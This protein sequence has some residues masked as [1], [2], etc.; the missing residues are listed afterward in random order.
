MFTKEETKVL[1]SLATH[2]KENAADPINAEKIAFW[3]RHTALKG[4]RP[5]VFVHPDGAWNELLP[6]ASLTCTGDFARS[7]EYKLRQRLFR[8]RYIPDDI[9]QVDVLKIQKLIHNSMWGLEP[10]FTP[11]NHSGGAWHHVVQIEKPSDWKKLKMPLV[12][13]DETETQ[14][15]FQAAGDVLGD[16]LKLESVGQTNCSFHMLHWYCDYRGLENLFMDLVEEPEMVHE[17]MEFFAE[18]CISMFPQLEAQ[19][20]LSLNNDET[21]H[22]TGG[23]GYNEEL[24]GEDFNPRHVKLKNLWASAEAQEFSSVSPAM[25]EEF[26]LQYE[27]RVFELFGLNGYGCCDDL[28]DKLDGVL[29]I[30]NLRRVAVCPWA[31]IAKFTP[32]LGKKYIMTWKPQPAFLAHETLAEQEIRQELNEGVKKAKGGILE[33]VL[34]DTHTC[35]REPERFTRWVQIAREAIKNQWQG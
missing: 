16:L 2:V 27:R 21:F 6:Y 31:D 7:I 24:P 14:K 26:V 1:R 17:R 34:R 18:G 28:S 32:R 9:P 5:A 22:Y 13:Y 12:E 29:Q 35:R 33:F 10:K 8:Q 20:L 30:K 23:I 4:E 11:S 25:H 15:R 19:N 3:K